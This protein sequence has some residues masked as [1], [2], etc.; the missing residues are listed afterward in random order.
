M[1]Q[2]R[3][4]ELITDYDYIINYH[5]GKANVVVDALSRKSSSLVSHLKM[6]YIPLLID[7][8]SLGTE[9]VVGQ[10]GA[11]LAHFQVRPILID[12]IREK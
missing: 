10:N 4:A 3:W 5:S 1:R 7:L 6:L 2:H 11:L 9:L 12:Q 8:R